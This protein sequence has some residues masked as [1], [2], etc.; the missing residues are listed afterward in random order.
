MAL[1]VN[2]YHFDVTRMWSVFTA[3]YIDCGMNSP[4]S[5]ALGTG[6]WV[7]TGCWLMSYSDA[8]LDWP[9]DVHYHPPPAPP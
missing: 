4:G 3:P 2:V 1:W 8:A 6:M 9:V 7:L 5:I